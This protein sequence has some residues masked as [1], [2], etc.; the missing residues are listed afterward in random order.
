MLR[1]PG[2]L[3]RW[4]PSDFFGCL[5]CTSTSRQRPGPSLRTYWAEKS[6]YRPCLGDAGVNPLLSS[7]VL[8]FCWAIIAWNRMWVVFRPT[9]ASVV[10]LPK[11]VKGW[12]RSDNNE[13]YS[14]PK[15]KKGQVAPNTVIFFW[16]LCYCVW[17]GVGVVRGVNVKSRDG[18]GWKTLSYFH[19]YIFSGKWNQEMWIYVSRQIRQKIKLGSRC[20]VVC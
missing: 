11:H 2:S 9:W 5:Y 7:C 10:P 12:F 15:K 6:R 14:V 17:W 3:G 16:F 20:Y 18:N 1:P 13:G 8:L 19:F 4:F